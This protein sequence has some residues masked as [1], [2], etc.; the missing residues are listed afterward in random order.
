MAP[1]PQISLVSCQLSSWATSSSI[2]HLSLLSVSYN[3]LSELCMLVRSK[4]RGTLVRQVT[5]RRTRGRLHG[6]ARCL[7][8]WSFPLGTLTSSH[9]LWTVRGKAEAYQ[10]LPV[11][12][13]SCKPIDGSL[14]VGGA[15]VFVTSQRMLISHLCFWT[16]G[17]KG[18]ICR[19]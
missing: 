11:T 10:R 6:S 13:H 3:L 5:A 19:N 14:R 15:L 18:F 7:F 8:V 17:E 1:L 9:C 12:Q 4:S 2:H 16:F